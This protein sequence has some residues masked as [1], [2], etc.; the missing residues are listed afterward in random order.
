MAQPPKA[1]EHISDRDLQKIIDN[2]G[3]YQF[4]TGWEFYQDSPY[5]YAA[6]MEKYWKAKRE[7]SDDD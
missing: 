6:R 2:G 3:K 1:S 7:G 5:A 4:V